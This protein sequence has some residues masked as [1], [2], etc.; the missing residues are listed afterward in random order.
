MQVRWH[1]YDGF[2]AD[3]TGVDGDYLT[4]DFGAMGHGQ[5]AMVHV[6]VPVT[7]AAAFDP[8][9]AM[10]TDD[11]DSGEDLDEIIGV[12]ATVIVI[13]LAIAIIIIAIASQSPE[14]G[15]GFGGGIDPDDWFWYTNGVH[16]IRCARSAPPPSGYHRTDPPPEFRAGGGKTRGGGVSRHHSNHSGCASSCACACASSCA[17]ACACAGGGRAGCSV[18]DF[19]T[20][21]LP[22]KSVGADACI[23]PETEDKR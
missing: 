7:N 5:Q 11:Y 10:T 6:T 20:V 12:L 1:N 14:W 9:A 18:K 13:L 15:G 21:K 16:T 22:K 8:G 17:C 23:G 19:Y 3:N 4:W 2:V